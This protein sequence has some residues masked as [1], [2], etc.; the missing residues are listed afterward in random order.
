M[1]VPEAWAR[2][3]DGRGVVVAAI[4]TGAYAEHEQLAGRQMSAPR[5]WFDPVEGSTSP[6]DNHGHG[7]GVL[8]MAVGGN[9]SGRVLGVA[10]RASWAVALG[11][12]HNYYSRFRMTLAADWILREARPDVLVNAWSHNEGRC[13]DFDLSL[14][15]AWKAAEIFVVFPAGNAGPSPRTGEAPAEMAG[16]FPDGR[17]VFSVAGLSAAGVIHEDSSRGPSACGSERFPTVAAPG[18]DLPFAYPSGPRGYGVGHGTSLAAGLVAGAATLLV[19]AAPELAPSEIERIL[20]ETARD[21]PPPG[22][23]DDTGFG[24]IDAAAALDLAL[25]TSARTAGKP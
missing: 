11:N 2:G 25:K 16:V 21:I 12:W 8:A 3:Y 22:P 6:H 4:D 14:I 7:T 24:G 19:Q 5:G 9:P 15:N 23:D 20:V 1:R 18:A 10:P 13:A 17:W